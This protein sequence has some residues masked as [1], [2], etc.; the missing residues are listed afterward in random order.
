VISQWIE[1]KRTKDFVTADRLRKELRDQGID[2]DGTRANVETGFNRNPGRDNPWWTE[3][4]PGDWRCPECGANVFASRNACY[5]CHAPK[6]AGGGPPAFSHGGGYGGGKGGGG[7]GY[8]GYGGGGGGGGYGGGGRDVGGSS[9]DRPLH[10]HT[11]P[12]DN[13]YTYDRVTGD[14]I[15]K[16]DGDRR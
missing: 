13:G 5:K 12:R 4:R 7:G 1:A 16:P 10:S 14:R 6:P 15:K 8:G 3:T 2:P 9:R 11:H